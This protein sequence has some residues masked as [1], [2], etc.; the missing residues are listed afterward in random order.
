MKGTPMAPARKRM[1]IAM[2]LHSSKR[3]CPSSMWW[4]ITFD[5]PHRMPCAEPA[6]D[7]VVGDAGAEQEIA[8]GRDDAA[9]AGEFLLARRGSA[10]RSWPS[11][12][13]TW[14]SRRCRRKRRPVTNDAASS[15]D[16]HLFA[17]AAVAPRQILPQLPGMAEPRPEPPLRPRLVSRTV[18]LDPE[19]SA[20]KSS[21]NAS[22]AAGCRRAVPERLDR[23]RSKS[24]TLTPCCSTQV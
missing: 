21:I 16:D 12:C 5:T 3:A 19:A 17:Q 6:G 4:R 22:H 11:A 18:S 9:R 8:I 13:A 24:S 14:W 10:P 2:W 23:R 15:S 1:P 20:L 7:N